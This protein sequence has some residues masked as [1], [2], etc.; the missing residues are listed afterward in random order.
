MITVI[1]MIF[2]EL[3]KIL[4]GDHHLTA[5]GG[6]TVI[7]NWGDGLFASGFDVPNNSWDFADISLTT[8]TMR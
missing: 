1:P 8:G 7:R 4:W 2:L 3:M 5:T 6:M